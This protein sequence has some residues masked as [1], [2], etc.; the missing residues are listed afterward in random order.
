MTDLVAEVL[1]AHGGIERWRA[2]TSISAKGRFGGILRSRFPGN[3]MADVAVR[4]E[5][6]EQRT[7][8]TDFPTYGQRTVFDRGDVQIESV[9]GDVLKSRHDARTAFTGI[10]SIRRAVRWD[11]LDAGYF[12][13][14]A[15]WNY[16]SIPLLLTHKDIEAHAGDP[17][18]GRGETW[19]RLEV[20]FPPEIHTHSPR[21]TFYVD[22]AG[23]IRRHDYIAEPIGRWAH[24]ANYSYDHRAFDGLVFPTRRR[25]YP[26]GPRSSA[27]PG[28]TL[29]AL[30]IDHIEVQAGV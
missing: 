1:D 17:W 26:I 29:V 21:Q 23:L 7:V 5:M 9:D 8:F 15:W 20:T 30:D 25:V 28:P 10:S 14:Y 3:R 24:A 18:R 16:L 19:R 6:T 2:V 27:L 4:I 22:S 11:S 12:A 13:G